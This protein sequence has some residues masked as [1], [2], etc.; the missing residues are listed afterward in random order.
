[1]NRILILSRNLQK[2]ISTFIV[3]KQSVRNNEKGRSK[4]D[5]GRKDCPKI[6]TVTIYGG[7][8]DFILWNK[9]TSSV[10]EA[11]GDNII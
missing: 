7:K 5:N 9:W 10:N 4:L 8:N 2:K 1:M 6:T 3:E 11:V